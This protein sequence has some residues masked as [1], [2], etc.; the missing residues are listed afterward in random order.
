MTN[1]ETGR[2]IELQRFATNY[3]T[4]LVNGRNVGYIIHG[5]RYV[6]AHRRSDGTKQTFAQATQAVGWLTK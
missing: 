4:V 2:N 1:T 3:D 5:L 6:T